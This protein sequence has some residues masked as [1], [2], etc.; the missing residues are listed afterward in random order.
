MDVCPEF[1]G[2]VV[3]SVAMTCC[4]YAPGVLPRLDAYLGERGIH[5]TERPVP[6]GLWKR[7]FLDA[8]G[9]SMIV[10]EFVNDVLPAPYL[11]DSCDVR[12]P[13]DPGRGSASRYRSWSAARHRSALPAPPCSMTAHSSHLPRLVSCFRCCSRSPWPFLGGD[14]IAGESQTGTLRYLLVT[15]V[16]R[17]HP[18]CSRN[19]P[20]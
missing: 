16:G 7:W 20:P 3:V 5:V 18:C 2:D 4:S 1:L 9:A 13:T 14:A 12:S 8:R 6:A 10:V 15:A 11:A 19:S 17:T